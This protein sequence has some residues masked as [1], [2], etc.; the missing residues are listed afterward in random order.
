MV[1]PVVMYGCE[2]WTLKKVEHRRI[3]SFELWCWRRLLRV[4]WTAKRSNQ[5]I[6]K[7]ISSVYSFEKTDVEAWTPIFWPPDAK[8][9]LIG[10]DPDA[11]KDWTGGEKDNRGWDGWMTSLTQ[12]TWVWISSGSWCWTGK[13]G[14]L[15]CMGLDKTEQLNY[16]SALSLVCSTKQMEKVK[17]MTLCSWDFK[18]A[19]NFHEYRAFQSEEWNLFKHLSKRCVSA[20]Q[21]LWKLE[22]QLRE[23]SPEEQALGSIWRGFSIQDV[24]RLKEKYVN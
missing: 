19:G 4:P 14:V 15:Q 16:C 3:D 22:Y 9:W 5:S 12:R 23:T 24:I 13:P 1:F 8:N 21:A 10:K 11:G 6:L 2:R 20:H 17:I 18:T 7:E